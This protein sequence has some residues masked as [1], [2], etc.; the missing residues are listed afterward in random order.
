MYRR[1]SPRAD[2]LRVYI[3]NLHA[4]MRRLSFLFADDLKIVKRSSKFE[5]LSENLHTAA[6]W[7]A[8]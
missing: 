4:E 5:D 8:Q 3:N 2:T 1:V 6:L 7:A